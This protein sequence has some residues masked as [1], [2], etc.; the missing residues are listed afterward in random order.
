[1][2][3]GEEKEMGQEESLMRLADYVRGFVQARLAEGATDSPKRRLRAD[4]Q[5]LVESSTIGHWRVAEYFRRNWDSQGMRPLDRTQVRNGLNA[6]WL[7]CEEMANL[8]VSRSG[9]GKVEL[10]PKVAP[11]AAEVPAQMLVREETVPAKVLEAPVLPKPVEAVSPVKDMKVE[12][13][14]GTEGAPKVAPLP[15][16]VETGSAKVPEVPVLPK[17]AEVGLVKAE[18][19]LLSPETPVSPKAVGPFDNPFGEEEVCKVVTREELAQLRGEL[20]LGKEDI[21]KKVVGAV[22]PEASWDQVAKAP[23]AVAPSPKEADPTFLV[24]DVGDK[25]MIVNA[26]R[27]SGL[28]DL[29]KGKNSLEAVVALEKEERRESVE[30]VKKPTLAPRM[31]PDEA[32]GE[33][34]VC[35]IVSKEELAQLRNGMEVAQANEAAGAEIEPAPRQGLLKAVRKFINRHLSGGELDCRDEEGMTPLIRAIHR[36]DLAETARLVEQGADLGRTD[37][38]KQPPLVVAVHADNLEAIKLILKTDRS[39][40]DSTDK[41]GRTPLIVSIMRQKPEFAKYLISQGANVNEGDKDGR[42]SLHY[43]A[44]A[45]NVDMIRLLVKSKA[46]INAVAEGT[47]RTPLMESIIEGQLEAVR[48]LLRADADLEIIKGP[49]GSTALGLAISRGGKILDLVKEA[50]EDRELEKI[51][52][53]PLPVQRDGL[54]EGAEWDAMDKELSA[55]PLDPPDG[56]LDSTD[57][58]GVFWK[59]TVAVGDKRV[60]K[61]REPAVPAA[62]S[63]HRGEVPISSEDAA[64]AAA[65][66]PPELPHRRPTPIPDEEFELDE[67]IEVVESVEDSLEPEKEV[68]TFSDFRIVSKE[69]AGTTVYCLKRPDGSKVREVWF[70]EYRESGDDANGKF[71]RIRLG[72]GRYNFFKSNGEM[73]SKWGANEAGD[74][75]QG[76]VRVRFDEGWNYW[77]QDGSFLVRSEDP[78]AKGGRK[79]VWLKGA[80]DFEPKADSYFAKVR[81][82]VDGKEIDYWIGLDGQTYIPKAK[83][84]DPVSPMPVSGHTPVYGTPKLSM[85]GGGFMEHPGDQEDFQAKLLAK[86]V[87]GQVLPVIED[88]VLMGRMKRIFTVFIFEQARVGGSNAEFLEAWKD[89]VNCSIENP[90]IDLGHRVIALK[91]RAL[92][93]AGK[94]DGDMVRAAHDNDI[95]ANANSFES[96]A[97]AALSEYECGEYGGAWDLLEM[98]FKLNPDPI[99]RYV[100]IKDLKAMVKAENGNQGSVGV[101]GEMEGPNSKG[102]RAQVHAKAP[103][104]GVSQA[105]RSPGKGKSEK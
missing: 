6:F 36:H 83:K 52:D 97:E 9:A 76:R 105:K 25:R 15:L 102:A 81:R 86:E 3:E 48:Y 101:K 14:V 7:R 55:V 61:F 53:T 93:K 30:K 22:D 87:H 2:A 90:T 40:V 57:W 78:G 42:T 98:T 99:G 75:V 89:Y 91:L 24:F 47:R 65:M 29:L 82:E 94:V 20:G 71:L 79:T 77:T 16:Q 8:S 31:S 96:W 38:A 60:L 5:A 41:K 56:L 51:S 32:W 10:L 49:D 34:E 23:E 59:M 45:G 19:C 35:K 21:E 28:G 39:L 26:D 92:R 104:N 58:D 84:Q 4:A 12:S 73:L 1:L 17:S 44:F 74:F 18:F 64:A 95:R 54:L 68:G 46:V 69:I 80:N 67:P 70:N 27:E 11:K 50:L 37:K 33:D 62:G 85:A 100:W 63:P 66:L 43:A 88:P 72:D 13:G 103:S